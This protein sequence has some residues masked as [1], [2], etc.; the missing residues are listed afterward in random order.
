MSADPPTQ[1]LVDFGQHFERS[2]AVA[3]FR[4]YLS[5]YFNRLENHPPW[6]TEAPFGP[7][8]AGHLS[9]TFNKLPLSAEP[10]DDAL[11]PLPLLRRLLPLRRP[12]AAVARATASFVLGRDEPRSRVNVDESSRFAKHVGLARH[13]G[14]RGPLTNCREF[15]SVTVRG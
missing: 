3:N 14:S 6:V 7:R 10:L 11:P 5:I 9:R 1:V 13:T 4:L 12:A 2:A 8:P 15:V